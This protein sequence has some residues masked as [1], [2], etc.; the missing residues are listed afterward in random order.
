[1][2]FIL[3]A[4]KKIFYNRTAFLFVFFFFLAVFFLAINQSFLVKA[5]PPG[6]G[7]PPTVKFVILDPNDSVVGVPVTVT[8]EAQKANSQVDAAYQNDVTLVVSGSATGGG[9]VDIVNGVGTASINNTV[10]ETVTLSLLDSENTGL[11]VN[12]TQEIIFSETDPPIAIQRGRREP[13]TRS[14]QFSGYAYP[15][16]QLTLLSREQEDFS[17]IPLA[18]GISVKDDGKFFVEI[19]NV[20]LGNY[21][22]ALKANDNF[23]IAAQSRFFDIDTSFEIENKIEVLMPPTVNISRT[24][25]RKGDF[26]IVTGSMFPESKIKFEIDGELGKEEADYLSLG[27]YKIQ[28]STADMSLG[29]HTI[30]VM[31]EFP[32]G[33][34]ISDFSILKNFSVSDIS[35]LSADLNGNGRVD[36][37]DWSIFLTRWNSNDTVIKETIDFNGDGKVDVSDF[38][39]FIRALKR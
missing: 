10:A 32:E 15:S 24:V 12:S 39:M 30:S 19:T 6:G 3:M 26:L 33:E 21:R 9:L 22:Y 36:I 31:Q 1:M 4:I 2:K 29:K 35:V 11:N 7:G 34:K 18:Q 13:V 38:S 20:S 5:G 17:I 37:G 14:I 23:G 27:T 8:I 28:I 25:I 16:A